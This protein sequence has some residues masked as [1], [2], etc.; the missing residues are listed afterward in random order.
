MSFGEAQVI[1]SVWAT[2]ANIFHVAPLILPA[3]IRNTTKTQ[4]SVSGRYMPGAHTFVPSPFDVSQASW[5]PTQPSVTE[6]GVGD[7]NAWARPCPSALLQKM[8]ALQ[9]GRAAG[10]NR[11][12]GAA[13]PEGGTSGRWRYFFCLGRFC[14]FVFLM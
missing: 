5:P 2:V 4:H 7:A 9:H 11:P 12:R 8:A 6:C 1:Y 14:L 13:A 3:V 10:G